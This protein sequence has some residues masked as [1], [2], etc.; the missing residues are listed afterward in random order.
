VAPGSSINDYN[1][2]LKSR[3]VESWNIG[4]QRSITPDTVLEVRYVANKSARAWASLNLNEVNI[5]ENQFLN[6]FQIAQNNLAVANGV[7]VP[8]LAALNTLTSTNFFSAGLPG[9]Q[10]VPILSTALANASNSTLANYVAQGQAGAFANSIAGNTAQMARLVGANYPA[11]LFEVNP[12]TGG[13]AAN[14][15]TNQGGST[16]N[17]MQVELR[18]RMAKGLT[19]GASYAWS[20]SLADGNILSL[21]NRAGVTYPSAFDQRHTIKLNWVYELPW[22]P[23]R[24]FLPSPGN[25][26]LRKAV[27]GWQVSGIMRL[28]TGT[29]SELLSGR[30]TFNTTDAGVVLHNITTNQLQSMMNIQKQGNGIVDFLP[31]SLITNTLAAFQLVPTALNPNA[32]Y[33]GPAN[34]AGQ[35]GNQVFL[36]GPWFQT[37]DVSLAKR[38]RINEKQSIEF[39]IQA[40]NIFN[41][42]NFFLVPN[43]SGNITMNNLFGQTQNAYNDINST[44][45]P[46]SRILDFQLRY[47]F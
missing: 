37:W 43:S 45:D 35:L 40:L 20:H 22:G 6:Q 16:Y 18:R 2:S 30:Q 10:A 38:T 29:P 46:G 41:H 3:Y 5:V 32:P 33:I 9:Q 13:S 39:R 31:Q 23:G 44:N 15:E 7:S 28:Q 4:L 8:Q 26:I 42:P 19:A 11:N 1:P 12:A 36:Y 25:P 14:L 21:R 17:S 27:E 47:S 24:A 34:T